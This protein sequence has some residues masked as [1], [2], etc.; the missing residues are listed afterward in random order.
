MALP[1]NIGDVID[2]LV[3]K[4]VSAITTTTNG[5]GLDLNDYEGQV[6]FYLESSAGTGTSPTLDVKIQ[7]SDDN[8]T[9]A[10]VSSAAFTQVTGAASVQKLVLNSNNVKRYV[11]C[12]STLTG[13]TP[14]FITSVYGM[15]VKKNYA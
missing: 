7:D 13:T 4:A 1:Y 2:R 10:D 14:S 6:A 11:R 5:T 3:L 12:V 8:T 15:G 9:F